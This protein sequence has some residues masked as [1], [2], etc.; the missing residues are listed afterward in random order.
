MSTVGPCVAGDAA[1][2]RIP[3]RIHSEMLGLYIEEVHESR[4]VQDQR[5]RKHWRHRLKSEGFTDDRI[6]LKVLKEASPARTG[7]RV[8]CM[9]DLAAGL[10]NCLSMSVR[11]TANDCRL[12]AR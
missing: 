10:N 11:A 8:G 6:A 2:E 9:I 5:C 1:H 3:E 12:S 7:L 4:L